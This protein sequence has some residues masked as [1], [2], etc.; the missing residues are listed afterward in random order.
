MIDIIAFAGD[1]GIAITEIMNKTLDHE[2]E[3][4]QTWNSSTVCPRFFSLP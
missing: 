4:G 3:S 2:E 1:T